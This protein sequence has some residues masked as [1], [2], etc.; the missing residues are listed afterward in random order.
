MS[1]IT[2]WNKVTNKLPVNISWPRRRYLVYSLANNSNLHRWKISNNSLLPLCN[3]LKPRLNVFKKCKEA[4]NCYTWTH[5]SILITIMEHLKP[6][7]FNSFCIYVTSLHLRSPSSRR[8]FCRKIPDI[9]RQ[10]GNKL[11][12]I[13]LTWPAETNLLLSRECKA[14]C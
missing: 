13:E 14:D 1:D 10:Q 11:I 7:P 9:A 6:K 5:D 4:L 3:K 2:T 8:L 12:V